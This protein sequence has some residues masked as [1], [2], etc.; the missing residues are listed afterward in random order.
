MRNSKILRQ[1]NYFSG[2][3]ASLSANHVALSLVARGSVVLAG[4]PIYNNLIEKQRGSVMGHANFI[5]CEAPV[6]IR[7]S[8]DPNPCISKMA[9]LASLHIHL[10]LDELVCF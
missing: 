8:H 5:Y 2:T 3:M 10:F 6:K 9:V 1:I 7:F 4:F